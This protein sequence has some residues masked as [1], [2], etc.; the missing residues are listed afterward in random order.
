MFSALKISR[1]CR[2]GRGLA[3]DSTGKLTALPRP[4]SWITGHSVWWGEGKNRSSKEG[5]EKEIEDRGRGKIAEGKERLWV[6][7]RE[8]NGASFLGP[9][10]QDPIDRSAPP[11]DQYQI[12]LL[13]NRGIC[14]WRTCSECLHESGTTSTIASRKITLCVTEKITEFA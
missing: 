5:K 10:P 13:H 3:R 8:R 11:S 12:I 14:M 2:C 6:R 1:K 7:G 4:C 9:S